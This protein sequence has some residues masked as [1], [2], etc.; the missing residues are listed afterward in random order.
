MPNVPATW[1]RC[2]AS[3]Q[4]ARGAKC[5]KKRPRAIF[6]A[7]KYTRAWASSRK[8]SYRCSHWRQGCRGTMA[9]FIGTMGYT[10]G[11]PHTCRQVDVA[12]C[13]TCATSSRTS[14]ATA[15]GTARLRSRRELAGG[16]LRPRHVGR[17]RL[18]LRAAAAPALAAGAAGRDPALRLARGA[19][20]DGAGRDPQ[21]EAGGGEAAAR[22]TRGTA[23]GAEENG[24]P[25]AE[26]EDERGDGQAG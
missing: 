4:A 1:G 24:P 25:P 7:L 23:G 2:P 15:F 14:S 16:Q 12:G 11:R 6:A 9:F 20:A 13:A 19:A 8:I 22:Q 3:Y 21:A 5:G 17:E 18:R 26:A 10:A